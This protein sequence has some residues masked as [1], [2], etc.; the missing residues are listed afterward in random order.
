M[1]QRKGAIR[2]RQAVLLSVTAAAAAGCTPSVMVLRTK[3]A[4]L[5]IK[6]KQI[7][8]LRFGGMDGQQLN[9]DLTVAISQA[10]QADGTT[11]VF[12]LVDRQSLGKVMQEQQL[13]GTGMIDENKA[14]QLSKLLPAAALIIGNAGSRADGQVQREWETCSRY[15]NG[16]SENYRC[17]HETR[18]V[19]VNYSAFLKIVDA[20]TGQVLAPSALRCTNRASTYAYDREPDDIDVGALVDSCRHNVVTQF[21]HRIA[22]YQVRERVY[23]VKTDSSL[24][25]LAAG[26]L[27]AKRSDWDDATA[28]YTKAVARADDPSSKI[29]PNARAE[30]HYALGVAEAFRGQYDEG[31]AQMESALRIL[32]KVGDTNDDWS[33]ML[34]RVRQWRS[35]AKKLQDQEKPQAPAGS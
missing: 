24:P 23:L 10:M 26:N 25:T 34:G 20:T 5:S 31:I 11:P 16:R 14:L 12:T 15:V 7:A 17:L 9:Q 28:E 2:W 30:A 4:E 19:T 21:M 6:A 22:P 3:P 35:D 8:V 29:E 33:E 13:A 1:A 18:T 27:A 32:E